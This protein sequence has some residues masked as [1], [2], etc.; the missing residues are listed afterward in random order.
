M[1]SYLDSLSFDARP[2]V[3]TIEEVIDLLTKRSCE[4]DRAAIQILSDQMDARGYS[5]KWQDLMSTK[6][7]LPHSRNRV[8]TNFR[9]RKD[10]S[11]DML[12]LE[13][14]ASR[15]QRSSAVIARLQ[16]GDEHL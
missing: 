11:S 7:Y 9:K 16:V 5:A 8:W 1:L 10:C 3:V 2:D 12:M 15:L 13:A 6:F 14:V 4:D